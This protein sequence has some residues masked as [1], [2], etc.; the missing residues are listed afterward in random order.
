[1][2]VLG[3]RVPVFF[4]QKNNMIAYRERNRIAQE[5]AYNS[6]IEID[7]EL[8]RRYAPKSSLLVRTLNS[9]NGATLSYDIIYTLLQ[10]CTREE[11]LR[12]R[13][14]IQKEIQSGNSGT[15]PANT[16]ASG[17]SNP[18]KKRP[19]KKTSTQKSS[20][21]TLKTQTSKKQS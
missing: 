17:K 2:R 18:E 11:I 6:Y 7:K 16:K 8:L 4:I 5:L 9:S 15:K 1:M 3:I 10:Y 13:E 19:R 14:S 20:G 12:N 21:E